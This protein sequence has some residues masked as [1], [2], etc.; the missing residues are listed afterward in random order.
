MF[1]VYKLNFLCFTIGLKSIFN[2]HNYLTK[3]LVFMDKEQLRQF[4]AK[5][6]PLWQA[7]LLN[8]HLAR[9]K[10]VKAYAQTPA[11]NCD[12]LLSTIVSDNELH[13]LWVHAQIID[14]DYESFKG[15]V[16]YV[17]NCCPF[18]WRIN[19]I[20]SVSQ[21][22]NVEFDK[23]LSM[24]SAV[25][26][27]GCIVAVNYNLLPNII[28]GLDEHYDKA[29]NAVNE[30]AYRTKRNLFLMLEC[31]YGQLTDRP[32]NDLTFREIVDLYL[33]KT[34]YQN[35]LEKVRLAQNNQDTKFDAN[36]FYVTATAYYSPFANENNLKPNAKLPNGSIQVIAKDYIKDVANLREQM[37]QHREI[38]PDDETLNVPYFHTFVDPSQ[39]CIIEAVNDKD[40]YAHIYMLR[41]PTDR[42]KNSL[43]DF[44]Y[45]ED[46]VL[47]TME[48]VK[49]FDELKPAQNF[50][51]TIN[52]MMEDALVLGKMI[53]NDDLSQSER[54]SLISQQANLQA[55]ITHK[56]RL[57]E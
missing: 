45:I 47:Y 9:R 5:K 13:D 38:D 33:P 36:D 43:H 19:L 14:N 23:P 46:N 50:A 12:E 28:K 25:C 20:D 2:S 4:I 37:E 21:M 18:L 55:V 54:F 27:I 42:A 53:E 32:I 44:I 26:A 24:D 49:N 56:F 35:L 51:D 52:A 17:T 57:P 40:L 8:F 11:N 10:F 48:V 29:L 16:W 22:F 6:D 30:K 7:I 31:E 1:F 34:G 3:Y 15:I 39:Q 41:Y